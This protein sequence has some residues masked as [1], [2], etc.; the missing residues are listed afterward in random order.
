MAQAAHQILRAA[1]WHD[2]SDVAV[3]RLRAAVA[4]AD[5]FDDAAAVYITSHERRARAIRLRVAAD[6]PEGTPERVARTLLSRLAPQ[7]VAMDPVERDF[8]F[9][10][11]LEKASSRAPSRAMVDA[12][13]GAWKTFAACVTP[14]QRTAAVTAFRKL[15]ERGGL[16]A[17]VIEPYRHHLNQAKL[18]DPE[19]VLWIAAASLDAGAKFA[20]RVCVVDDIESLNPARIAFIEAVLRHSAASLTVLRGG[21]Q[22]LPF[23]APVNEALQQIVV[24]KLGGN[25]HPEIELPQLPRAEVLSAWLEDRTTPQPADIRLIQP[26]MRAAEV[27]EAARA[28]KTWAV[29]GTPLDEICVALPRAQTYR[30]LIEREFTAAG[31]PFD[32]PFDTPLARTQPV[33]A[34]L[35][36][37]AVARGGIDRL[38]LFDA[39]TS[40]YLP[41]GSGDRL[42]RLRAAT[43][44]AGIVGGT[45]WEQDWAARLAPQLT[46]PQVQADAAWLEQIIAAIA[47]FTRDRARAGEFFAAIFALI[48]KSGIADVCARVGGDG[49][50]PAAIVALHEFRSLCGQLA[51]G[52][53][54]VGDKA[55]ELAELFRALT[56]QAQTRGARP[57]Q[58]SSPRVQVL[59]LLDLGVEAYRRAI[60]LGLSDRDLPLPEREDFFFAPSAEGAIA[61]VLGAAVARKL[62]E[63][64]D[65][66]A[67]ADWLYARAITAGAEQLVLSY[68][69]QE[70]EETCLPATQ[71]ARLLRTFK[72]EA[73]TPADADLHPVSAHGLAAAAARL[74]GEGQTVL[75]PLSTE[76]RAGLRGRSIELA[77]SD[78]MAAPGIFDGAV[79]ES[80]ALAARFSANPAD[81]SRPYSP[82][83]LDM[84]A[85]CPQRFWARHVLS[86]KENR[87][88]TRDTQPW[89]VGVLVH[90]ALHR[91]VLLVRDALGQPRTLESPWKRQGVRALDLGNGDVEA[92]RAKSRTLMQ[93]ALEEARQSQSTPGPFWAGVVRSLAAGLDGKDTPGLL[94]RVID[95]ELERNAAG[96]GVRWAEFSFGRAEHRGDTTDMLNEP[97]MLPLPDG[98]IWLTG[99]IDRVDE[100]PGGL[101]V[102]DYKTNHARKADEIRDGAAFQLPVYLAAL[103]RGGGDAPSGMLYLRV[104]LFE[105]VKTIDATRLRANSKDAAF[106]VGALVTQALPRRLSRMLAAMRAGVFIHVPFTDMG[107]VCKTCEFAYACARRNDVIEERQRRAQHGTPPL[108]AAYLPEA[109]PGAAP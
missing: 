61:R 85:Q 80:S 71:H 57:S 50:A 22:E 3:Q 81:G 42:P 17:D 5:V 23:V 87:E 102:I 63:P 74:G 9:F 8:K 48:D 40:P 92:A 27:N 1:L 109:P 62:V 82:S 43:R 99:S 19:D 67:Q 68:P 30:A 16:F 98:C 7:R 66:S 47:P 64:I 53:E 78:L 12:L 37:I 52:F 96:F 91:F 21:A 69:H 94:S 83:Q 51:R 101:I 86:V 58:D 11:L 60:V 39:L 2:V 88:P 76:I 36:L 100:G 55:R 103:A 33:A 84:Y 95:S 14:E 41:F 104:P 29:A 20:P 10:E 54:R 108:P 77:R 45:R 44:S 24:G 97:L 28:I 34:L 65:I 90:G 105:P 15:G 73:R 107:A 89:A 35:E 32:M 59:G 18:D 49:S 106:D 56:E 38:Q 25:A 31:I 4:D 46:S 72:A 26:A 70:G 93:Q 6:F 13:L 79:G 75:S